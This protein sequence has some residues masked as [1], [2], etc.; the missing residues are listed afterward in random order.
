MR[1][2]DKKRVLNLCGRHGRNSC[3]DRA[4]SLN[5]KAEHRKRG[6]FCNSGTAI[7]LSGHENSSNCEFS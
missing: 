7:K 2:S 6:I 3:S 1:L 5:R 4:P